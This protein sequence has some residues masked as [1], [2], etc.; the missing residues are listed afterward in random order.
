MSAV[1]GKQVLFMRAFQPSTNLIIKLVIICDGDGNTLPSPCAAVVEGIRTW[2][3]LSMWYLGLAKGIIAISCPTFPD[4]FWVYFFNFFP[5]ISSVLLIFWQ[6][7]VIFICLQVREAKSE[8]YNYILVISEEAAVTG[9]VTVH[10]RDKSDKSVMSIEDL[11]KFF[12]EEI[13]AFH[14]GIWI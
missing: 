9:Q 8:Q 13:A 3:K 11:L 12:K 4:L 5:P 10:A 7:V 2:Q 14:W 6:P 1:C